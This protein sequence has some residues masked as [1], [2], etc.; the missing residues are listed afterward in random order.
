MEEDDSPKDILY[1]FAEN[2]LVKAHIELMLAQLDAPTTS[3]KAINQVPEVYNLLQKKMF[4]LKSGEL[5]DGGN[6]TYTLQ[7]KIHAKVML[8]AN[9]DISDRLINGQ[10]GLVR[11][12]QM[13]IGNITKVYVEF[14]DKRA[15]LKAMAKENLPHTN[16]WF[17]S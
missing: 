7:L 10:I 9:I 15:G 1:I 14:N 5:S 11:S 17:F 6:L 2:V 12:F 3:I 16:R 4:I 13:Q 8:A